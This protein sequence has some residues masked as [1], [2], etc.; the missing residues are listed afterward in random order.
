[1]ETPLL[2]SLSA[3]IE[4]REWASQQTDADAA[5][6]N[7][8]RGDW[9]LWL[10]ERANPTKPWSEERKPIAFCACECARQALKY[11]KEGEERPRISIET[12][13][14]W[15]RGEASKEEVLN[16]AG[17]AGAAYA[18]YTAYTADAAAAAAYA[19][20]AAY[21][22]NAAAAAAAAYAAYAAAY[23]AAG[24]AYAAYAADAADAAAADAAYGDAR[25][26]SLKASANI[27]R[28]HFPKRPTKG[29]N[30]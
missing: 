8:E 11:L 16:A 10:V 29:E 23:A 7:C 15:C 17:A 9:M 3:C 18:A 6:D 2:D 1:M 20:Y 22:A 25:K 24:A 14:A 26:Q 5:W 4:A 19:A 21:T 13:E 27:V 12:T 28:K 30:V